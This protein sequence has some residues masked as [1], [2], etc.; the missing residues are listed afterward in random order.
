M[1]WGLTGGRIDGLDAEVLGDAPKQLV[2]VCLMLDEPVELLLAAVH[3][4]LGVARDLLHPLD[5]LA[6]RV[7]E[8]PDGFP[9][10]RHQSSPQGAW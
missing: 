8:A 7:L 1:G 10:S 9:A 5:A 6:E 2:V 3:L 4:L